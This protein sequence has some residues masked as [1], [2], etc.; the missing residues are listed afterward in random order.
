MTSEGRGAP[1]AQRVV[2]S[3]QNEQAVNPVGESPARMWLW[4][5]LGVLLVIVGALWLRM[6]SPD[7]VLAQM[8]AALGL[9]AQRPALVQEVVLAPSREPQFLKV[10][11]VS[12]NTTVRDGDRVIWHCPERVIQGAD[13]LPALHLIPLGAYPQGAALTLHVAPSHYGLLEVRGVQWGTAPQILTP[14]NMLGSSALQQLPM[15]LLVSAVLAFAY[16][17][18]NVRWGARWTA[19]HWFTL[20]ALSFSL[21]VAQWIFAG[22]FA[23]IPLLAALAH[24]GRLGGYL[25]ALLCAASYLGVSTPFKVMAAMVLMVLGAYWRFASNSLSAEILNFVGVLVLATW[26]MVSGLVMVMRRRRLSLAQMAG[27]VPFAVTLILGANDDLVLL[28]FDDLLPFGLNA[29]SY[30]LIFLAFFL[31]HMFYRRALYQVEGSASS[32]D[33][34]NVKG[35][36]RALQHADARVEALESWQRFYVEKTP[37]GAFVL[38]EGDVVG[39]DV[40]YCNPMAKPLFCEGDRAP[41]LS[42][43]AKRVSPGDALRVLDFLDGVGQE[44]VFEG[45]IALKP[46]PNQTDADTYIL[47]MAKS[48]SDAGVMRVDG[49]LLCISDMRKAEKAR[50]DHLLASQNE[51]IAGLKI[52]ERELLARDLHDGLAANLFMAHLMCSQDNYKISEISEA[53]EDCVSELYAIVDMPPTDQVRLADVLSQ[54]VYRIERRIKNTAFR[55]DCAIDVAACPVVSSYWALDVVRVIQEL[56]VNAM[57]HSGGHELNLSV[58]FA[59]APER[60]LIQ[61]SDDGNGTAQAAESSQRAN[62][63]GQLVRIKRLNAQVSSNFT[64]QGTTVWVLVPV[65]PGEGHHAS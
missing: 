41:T 8:R 49:V 31:A 61:V 51:Q 30:L 46:D 53:L 22:L 58:N 26:G 56:L 50:F 21:G 37:I 14:L 16:G 62:R 12:G 32:D 4:W 38:T 35:L 47:R 11:V 17:A 48:H 39:F 2:M 45:E 10:M 28:G 57:R 13:C 52:N 15:L 63:P 24:A 54:L 19:V 23:S 1:R 18:A 9:Q 27:L 29:Y 20:T 6:H 65:T 33:P 3:M 59:S 43:F 34:F 25:F 40:K 42:E 64:S 44:T 7:A 36:E 60:L 5:G 55:L